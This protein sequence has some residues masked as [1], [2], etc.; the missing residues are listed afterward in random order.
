MLRFGEC[1]VNDRRDILVSLSNKTKL[2]T[3]FD[4]PPIPSFKFTPTKG[5]L[6]SLE[7]ISIV[8]SFLPPQLGKFK[9]TLQMLV[10]EGLD[11][12]QFKLLGE[13]D[14][15]GNKKTLIGG[16]NKAPD[17]FKVNLKFVD[18]REEKEA[19]V[20]KKI[21]QLNKTI[22]FHKSLEPASDKELHASFVKHGIT[23]AEFTSSVTS[24]ERD[25]IYKTGE[26]I[27]KTNNGTT[28]VKPLSPST[29]SLDED[30]LKDIY[31]QKKQHDDTY[32]KFLQQSYHKRLENKKNEQ[33]L[34]TL[35][36]GAIN[37]DDPFGV[38]MGMDRGLDEPYL[39]LPVVTEPLWLANRGIEGNGA[40]TRL[41]IDENRLIQKKY[42]S[43]AITQAELRDCTAELS[44][45]DLKLICAS[46]KVNYYKYISLYH[47]YYVIYL[48]IIILFF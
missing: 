14:A 5:V 28:L 33:K 31:L 41:P 9:N 21:N 47:L 34:K 46:H 36:K 43:S 20:Q 29:K 40:Q 48:I 22:A 32:N 38:N 13:C 17:D 26:G 45:E 27:A 11:F 23:S 24:Q 19:R 44:S 37:F 18:P 30:Q 25:D 35:S 8:A 16:I 3:S 15:V 4:F 42:S 10:A 7:T 6:Q 12:I 1:P 39:P 2:P